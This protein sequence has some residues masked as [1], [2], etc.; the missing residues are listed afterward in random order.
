MAGSAVTQEG[1]AIHRQCHSAELTQVPSWPSFAAQ[2]HKHWAWIF[3]LLHA[4]RLSQAT[5]TSVRWSAFLVALLR[6]YQWPCMPHSHS[7]IKF[8]SGHEFFLQGCCG[9]FSDPWLSFW[10]GMLRVESKKQKGLCMVSDRWN[11]IACY[12]WNLSIVY[13]LMFQEKHKHGC[14]AKGL[15]VKSVSFSLHL[16]EM[17]CP[18]VRTPWAECCSHSCYPCRAGRMQP[19][20]RG[21]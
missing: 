5:S 12:A 16:Q 13:I 17:A 21:L 20:L 1:E 2:Q 15:Q 8:W 19:S 10:H 9:H 3:S 18:A 14:F 7:F 6:G 4:H 11:C